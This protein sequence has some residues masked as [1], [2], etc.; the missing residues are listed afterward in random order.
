[1]II[2]LII[3]ASIISISYSGLKAIYTEF[4]EKKTLLLYRDLLKILIIFQYVSVLM[5]LV[6]GLGF[7]I[8]KFDFV[9]DMHELNLDISDEEEVE[10]T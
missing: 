10:L 4:L 3:V 9:K 6:R 8:K 1:M 2:F 5:V 7:D